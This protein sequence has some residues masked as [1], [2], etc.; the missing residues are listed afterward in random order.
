M[1]TWDQ[2][3][4]SS[5]AARLTRAV[6]ELVP[7]RSCWV[8][9]PAGLCNAL[10]DGSQPLPVLL[11]VTV[12]DAAG[13]PE[14]GRP[15]HVVAW[16]GGVSRNGAAV[17]QLP[18]ELGRCLGV[19]HG[20]R[21][22]LA[23]LARAAIPR[24]VSVEVEPVGASDWEVVEANAGHL[25]DGLLRQVAVVT[26]GQTLPVW[27]RGQAL[28]RL[29]VK[30]CEPQGGPVMLVDGTEVYVAPKPRRTQQAQQ[31]QQKAPGGG[32]GGAD[33]WAAMR[34]R[35]LPMGPGFLLPMLD[36]AGALCSG[37][38]GGGGVV[39]VGGG[40][41]GGSGSGGGAAT[42][43]WLTLAAV[44]SPSMVVPCRGG[45]D[46]AGAGGTERVR[47][48]T[49]LLL[50]A[51]R[52]SDSPLGRVSVVALPSTLCPDGHVM[53]APP[54]LRALGLTP[55]TQVGGSCYCEIRY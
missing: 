28:V 34:L 41:G 45:G 13:L 38:G 36:A 17:L 55:H 30:A 26:P 49:L 54:L 12:L 2:I 47:A 31:A 52:G 4:S 53:L 7:E 20:A 29:T 5:A 33:V 35:A 40:G 3:T 16:G 48:G 8:S 46:G 15:Q 24:A 25:E 51:D 27:V 50:S 22:A 18:A 23:P 1:D 21:V 9:L 42:T 39:A 10:Y 44:V 37:G 19:A 6:V 43:T 11:R 14:A 32:A